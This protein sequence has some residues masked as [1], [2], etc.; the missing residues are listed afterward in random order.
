MGEKLQ[1]VSALVESKVK[2]MQAKG[3]ATSFSGSN[4]EITKEDFGDAVYQGMVN[5]LNSVF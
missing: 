4:R 1:T 3:T 5:A 2:E